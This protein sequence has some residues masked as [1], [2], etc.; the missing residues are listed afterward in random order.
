MFQTVPVQHRTG[1]GKSFRDTDITGYNE[2]GASGSAGCMGRGA[3]QGPLVQEQGG[4]GSAVGSG[5]VQRAGQ[6]A[7]GRAGCSRYRRVQWAGCS[8]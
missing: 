8:R 1:P 4:A 5:R 3:A 2:Q 7:E 6:G